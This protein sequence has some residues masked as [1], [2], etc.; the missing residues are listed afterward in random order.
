MKYQNLHAHTVTSDGL[1]T[2]KEVLNV[3]AK[4]NIGV[5]AFTDHDSLPNKKAMDTTWSSL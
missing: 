5:L 1:L 4:N 3:C 2:Y